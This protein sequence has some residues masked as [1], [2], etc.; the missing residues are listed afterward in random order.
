MKDKKRKITIAK[1]VS[2][3]MGALFVLAA[4][5]LFIANFYIPVKYLSAYMLVNKSV[6]QKGTADVTFLDVD[7]GNAVIIRLP[8]GKSMV[9]DGG[10]NKYENR[11]QLITEINRRNIDKIDYLVCSAVTQEHCGA[12][13]ELVKYKPIGTLYMPACNNYYI[14]SEYR[15]VYKEVTERKVNTQIYEYG[16][17]EYG[18]GYFF[19][20]LSP[21]VHTNPQGEY[22]Y[23]NK[24]G[25]EITD[26]VMG[27]ASA[28]LW[29][30]CLGTS[31]LFASDAGEPVFK[32]IVNSY[33]TCVLSNENYAPI[34]E[35][36]V[37]ITQLDVMMVARHGGS[38]YA[39]FYD[40][41]KPKTAIVS[42]GLNGKKFPTTAVLA[43]VTAHAE[44]F[45]TRDCGNI[46]I[47]MQNGTYSVKKE[48]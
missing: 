17:G 35:N 24:I 21:S 44:T 46:I 29:L 1:I 39:P 41:A 36:S 18:D 14:T 34:G 19:T 11:L 16:V 7:Y 9:I 26:E 45:M 5:A 30:E 23:L 32:K 33:E 27:N 20:F 38:A 12:L 25:V 37:D 4:L 13:L 48:K 28:V 2:T 40:L 15:S 31:F 10:N 43:T 8:D 3:T 47:K 42:V 6:L 22:A